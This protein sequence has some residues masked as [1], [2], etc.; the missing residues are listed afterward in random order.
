MHNKIRLLNA[1]HEKGI[2]WE[3]LAQMDMFGA[4]AIPFGS[5]AS[6]AKGRVPQNKT[7]RRVFGFTKEPWIRWSDRPLID[8]P[9]ELVKWRLENREKV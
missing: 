2:T 3:E 8:Q 1:L 9:V 6:Y 4:G 5:L 7:H